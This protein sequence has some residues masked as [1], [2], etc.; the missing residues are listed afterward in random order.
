[1]ADHTF[2]LYASLATEADLD[3]LCHSSRE[4]DLY[5]E[6]KQKNDRR[7]ASLDDPDRKN[8][9]KTVAGFANADGGVLLFGIKT[10]RT[11]DGVDR[12]TQLQPISDHTQFRARLLDSI[13][14]TTQ[15]VV[16]GV[17]IDTIDSVSGGGYVKCL[18]PQSIRAPHRAVAAEHQYWR[19][20]A[21]G[22]RRM[23]HYELEDLFGRRLRPLLSLFVEL[24]PRPDDDPHE[25]IHFLVLNEG[26]GIA[27]HLGFFVQPNEAKV[28]GVQGHG[29]SNATAVNDCP[30]ITYYDPHHVVHA[31][32]I[33]L[34]AGHAIIRRDAKGAPLR[35]TAAWYA[36]DAETKRA[37]GTV[38]TGTRLKLG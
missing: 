15:P 14:T 27:R 21:V 11:A 25:E 17:Q 20:T 31:N 29:L 16:D 9:S 1:M 30:T 2:R 35:V 23:D 5:I 13:F 3:S 7:Q 26:R 10:T 32:G 33:Y 6:F 22:H 12:A 36:E 37:T 28:E 19:R 24:R 38:V 4:E 18:V 34:S 8:F